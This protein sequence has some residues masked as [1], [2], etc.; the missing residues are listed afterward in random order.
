MGLDCRHAIAI[1]RQSAVRTGQHPRP[2]RKEAQDSVTAN[3]QAQDL[4]GQDIEAEAEVELG[5]TTVGSSSSSRD[6]PAA[7]PAEEAPLPSV[8]TDEGLYPPK[9]QHMQEA[10]EGEVPL[11]SATRRGG[12]RAPHNRQRKAVADSG[13]G[14]ERC[15]DWTRFDVGTVLRTLKRAV[16]KTTIK[17]ELRKLRLRWWR[18]PKSATHRVLEAAG[19]PKEM[20]DLIPDVV[21]T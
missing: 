16:D 15:S 6:T 3:E 8:P 7:E 1:E 12:S 13:K 2:P 19:L 20:L 11:L 5:Q 18:A 14:A 10:V 4:D 21:D 9:A 17:R